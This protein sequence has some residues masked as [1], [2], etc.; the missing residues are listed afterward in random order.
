ME[1]FYL[2][3][4]IIAEVIAA[5]ALKA[6]HGLTRLWPVVIM[7]VSYAFTFYCMTMALRTIPLGVTYAIWSGVGIVLITLTSVFFFNEKVDMPA[8][9]GMGLIIAGVVVINVF[10]KIVPH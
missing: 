3:L 8:L 10:S 5:N 2:G 7:C 9:I 4:A 1:Y 6:S